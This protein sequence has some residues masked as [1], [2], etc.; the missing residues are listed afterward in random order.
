MVNSEF[1]NGSVMLY[2]T[3]EGIF[4]AYEYFFETNPFCHTYELYLSIKDLGILDE[5]NLLQ[6]FH[7]CTQK[8]VCATILWSFVEVGA[9]DFSNIFIK[10]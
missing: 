8:S 10:Y 1:A 6:H 5:Y 4:T 2:T 9:K 7:L 3:V